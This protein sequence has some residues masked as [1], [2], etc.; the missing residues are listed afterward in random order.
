MVSEISLVS[1]SCIAY[2]ALV[3][4]L[5]SMRAFMALQMSKLYKRRVAH[6]AGER[7]L[8]SM[9]TLM[10]FQMAYVRR[11]VRAEPAPA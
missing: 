7:T 2:D 10:N 1:K 4:L 6:R 9:R 11:L 3:R 5:S 8:A